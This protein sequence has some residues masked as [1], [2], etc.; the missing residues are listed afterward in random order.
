MKVDESIYNEILYE[1]IS[2]PKE[3]IP[4]LN[5]QLVC[6]NEDFVCTEILLIPFYSLLTGECVLLLCDRDETGNR[7]SKMS[8]YLSYVVNRISERF[9][10]NYYHHQLHKLN[11]ELEGRVI[12]RTNEL[13]ELTKQLK[14]EIDE[15]KNYENK[16]E[17]SEAKLSKQN[18]ELV[19]AIAKAKEIDKLKSIFFANMSHELRTPLV[20]LLGFSEILEYEL[21]GEPRDFALKIHKSGQRLLNTLNEILTYSE[22][23]AGKVLLN[24]EEVDIVK[25]V[26]DEIELFYILAAQKKLKICKKFEVRTKKMITDEKLLRS[27]CSNLINNAI[28][29]TLEGSVT[30][31]LSAGS[32]SVIISVT[33]TGIGIPKDKY[34]F[35]FEEFRQVSEGVKRFFDGAGLGLSI[36]KKYCELLSGTISVESQENVGSIF[37]VELPLI[38]NTKKNPKPG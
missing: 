24:L 23:E 29:Y 26:D 25:L 9:D 17:T 20:G 36:V 12:E 10:T 27:I 7:L 2:I 21:S 34:N 22:L 13:L 31:S 38:E 19:N 3:K 14:L 6:D 32:H 18:E 30:V 37:K 35:I 28:K 16:L 33:D 8:S 11:H 15:R 4:S 1:V 5:I